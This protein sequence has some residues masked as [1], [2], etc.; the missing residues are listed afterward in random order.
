MEVLTMST[1]IELIITFVL[2][3]LVCLAAILPIAIFHTRKMDKLISNYFREIDEIDAARLQSLKEVHAQ[4]DELAKPADEISES[5]DEINE[6]IGEINED[7]GEIGKS[8]DRMNESMD[9]TIEFK[10]IIS[11]YLDNKIKRIEARENFCESQFWD[12]KNIH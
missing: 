5:A 1:I 9:R 6:D 2:Y 8:L 7:I 4:V 3:F 11:E 10:R 12:E